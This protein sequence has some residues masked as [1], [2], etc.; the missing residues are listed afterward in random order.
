VAQDAYQNKGQKHSMSKNEQDPHP[1]TDALLKE[2]E[3]CQK[4]AQGLEAT[5]WQTSGAMGIG[6]IGTLVLVANRVENEQP[7]WQVAAVIGLFV[8]L[9]SVAW[10][11]MARRWWSIQH[12]YFIRM[13]HIEEGLGLYAVR[14]LY[15]LDNPS[16]LAGSGLR[17]EYASE[18]A[19]RARHQRILP[20]HQRFGVQVVLSFLP[21]AVL[22]AW[23]V[24]TAWLAL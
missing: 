9:I 18:L 16:A 8:F 11:F 17:E 3:L 6:L 13:R 7:P 4:A 20:T 24:Y 10:F 5:I 2:Y 1:T 21:V 19:R 22:I 12:A 15:F 23:A 14:Y